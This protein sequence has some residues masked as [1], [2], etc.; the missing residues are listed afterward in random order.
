M[1]VVHE[2]ASLLAVGAGTESPL[3]YFANHVK[4]M[5]ATDLYDNPDHEGTPSM[6]ENPY[7]F[8]PFPYREDHLEVY[9]MSGD[10]LEFENNSFDGVFSLSS[11]EHFGSRETQKNCVAEIARVL[12]PGGVACLITELILNGYSDD[13]YFTLEEMADVFFSH[14]ELELVGGEP[15]YSISK[16]LVDNPVVIGGVKYLNR[17]PHIVLQRDEMKWTSFS[18]FLRKK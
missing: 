11:I 1:G 6:L 8:A 17:S 9:R 3:Y 2:D 5:V 14:P 4:R 15:D 18:I 12:K 13:E 10:N 7:Q 16:S